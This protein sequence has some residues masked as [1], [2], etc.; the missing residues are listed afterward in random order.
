MVKLKVPS[1]QH[2][3]RIWHPEPKVIARTLIA[4]TR[5][6]PT[7]SY[8][9]LYDAVRD[10]CLFKIP[11]QDVIRGFEQRI[12]RK[13]VRDNFVG[14]MPLISEYFEGAHPTFFQDITP[15][16]YPVGRDLQIPFNPPFLF[17]SENGICF[18]W[19]IFWKK[20]PLTGQRLS[21]FATV[22][23]NVLL[24][25]P[26]LDTAKFQLVDFSAPG[27]KFSRELRVVDASLVPRVSAAELREMLGVFAEGYKLAMAEFVRDMHENG[28]S[29]NRRIDYDQNQLGLFD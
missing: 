29:S 6:S 18:P 28:R 11:Y 12:Q 20:N 15:R 8:A 14:L 4:L 13:Q 1:L 9:P 24:Q 16:L 10:M 25:D 26:D 27:P 5:N 21:L 22:V 17:G 23:D 2:L 19:L 7:F 3:S